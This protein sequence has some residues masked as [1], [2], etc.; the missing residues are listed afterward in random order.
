[1]TSDPTTW[2]DLKVTLANWLNR[3][4]LSTVE[5]PEAIAL[6]ERRF[7]RTLFTPDRQIEATLTASAETVALPTDFW[8]AKAAYITTD[9]KTVLEQMTLSELR[10]VYSSN[11]TGLPQNYAIRGTSMI[12][13]PAPDT[14]YS[15]KLTYIQ[16]I[17][18]LGS[19][20]ASNWLLA[21][22]PDI[23]VY[24]SLAELNILLRDENAASIF[25]AKYEATAEEINQ[26][27]L[28]RN[29]GQAPLR[30]RSPVV[31]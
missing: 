21:A 20:Q 25:E 5:I 26:S 13:G 29:Y 22:H 27:G 30:I 4:D 2:T 19:G 15:I 3:T 6:A 8:G 17:P 24:G 7:Q 18:A 1:M 28:R 12:L 11:T 9:P 10:E 31:V 16:T 14:T 23:Y